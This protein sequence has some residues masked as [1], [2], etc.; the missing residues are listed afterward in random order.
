MKKNHQCLSA[1]LVLVMALGVFPVSASAAAKN[2]GSNMKFVNFS[3]DEIPVLTFPMEYLKVT[4]PAG[5]GTH[6]KTDAFDIAGKD[7]GADGF[8]APV[9]LVVKK[10]YHAESN[11]CNALFLESKS[12]CLLANGKVS[13][14]TIM[15]IHVSNADLKKYKENQL[16]EAGSLVCLESDHGYASGKHLHCEVSDKPYSGW[17]KVATIKYGGEKVGIW[18]LNDTIPADQAF[19]VDKG[20]TTVLKENGYHFSEYINAD[21]S[22]TPRLL[23]VN[24]DSNALVYPEAGSGTDRV[25]KKGAL[26][27]ANQTAINRDTQEHYYKVDGAWIKADSLTVCEAESGGILWANQK[28]KAGDYRLV[29]KASQSCVQFNTN[30]KTVQM[31]GSA[32]KNTIFTLRSENGW[33]VLAPKGSKLVLNSASDTPAKNTKLNLYKSLSGDST[34]AFVL[35][36]VSPFENEYVIRLAYNPS[37]C[38]TETNGTLKLTAY[39]GSESQIWAM[40]KA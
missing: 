3:E 28:V 30:K 37:L 38:V 20:A 22:D 12:T 10:V 15:L 14:V 2:P 25:Y 4:Q 31:S 8:Y 9:D 27:Y 24:K 40:Q 35:Q 23:R 26:I 29:N 17:S 11:M 16:I 5:V 13:K 6:V 36:S 32:D 1:L 18:A 33:D 21:I 7:S 39:N 19:W 34:Q